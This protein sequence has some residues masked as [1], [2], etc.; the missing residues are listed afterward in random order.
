MA[1]PTA[2][3][4]SYAWGA[5]PDN[6]GPFVF[7]ANAELAGQ[8][9]GL[10]T[11]GVASNRWLTFCL[12]KKE[13]FTFGSTYD[14]TIDTTAFAGGY[15]NSTPGSGLSHGV[16]F[17]GAGDALDPRTAFLYSSFMA[18]TLDNIVGTF[19]YNVLSSGVQ[20]QRAIWFLENELS[21][22]TA[23]SLAATLVSAANAAVAPGGDW[24]GA[25]LGNVR[26]L[27]LWDR[28]NGAPRQSQLVIIP[29]P[30]PAGL[31]MAG[32]LGIVAIRRRR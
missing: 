2:K 10:G 22:V 14:A 4:I 17:A 18:G 11:L 15:G 24:D 9:S 23:G 7:E 3:A 30:G 12:E 29:L 28:S 8:I 21:S 31:A 1:G 27:N 19:S 5:N 20:L 25:G 6:G 13:T 16:S 26:V 32:V